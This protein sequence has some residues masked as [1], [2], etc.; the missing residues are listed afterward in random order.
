MSDDDWDDWGEEDPPGAVS[1]ASV[2]RQQQAAEAREEQ[3][4]AVQTV[5]EQLRGFQLDLADEAVMDNLNGR[6]G[7]PS[8][9]A[10]MKC[11]HMRLCLCACVCV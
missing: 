2:Q 11:V 5:Q 8:F 1:S 3:A 4:A 7:T 6:L 9:D 10:F